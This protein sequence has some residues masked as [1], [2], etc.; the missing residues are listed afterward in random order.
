MEN[1]RKWALVTGLPIM[2][3]I[4]MGKRRQY[5]EWHKRIFGIAPL[6][7]VPLYRRPSAWVR[8]EL[9]FGWVNLFAAEVSGN[10][11]FTFHPDDFEKWQA[12]SEAYYGKPKPTLPLRERTAQ[13]LKGI[14]DR[15]RLA[16]S[17]LLTGE[18]PMT[19]PGV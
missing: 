15:V 16:R 8:H 11:Y 5:E 7:Y 1:W 19:G 10:V 3:Y 4:W 6:R 12:E 13:F 2:A 17:V 18:L 9:L 14:P